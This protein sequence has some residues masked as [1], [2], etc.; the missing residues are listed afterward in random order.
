M[1]PFEAYT[2]NIDLVVILEFFWLKL[3]L[4]GGGPLAPNLQRIGSSLSFDQNENLN[5]SMA[6]SCF[7]HLR[8]LAK[9][10]GE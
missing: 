7:W 2:A 5:P 8:L 6:G 3:C 1:S 9:T 10:E 4:F